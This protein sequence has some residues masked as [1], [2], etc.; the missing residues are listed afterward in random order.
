VTLAK[1]VG[2]FIMRVAMQE[3]KNGYPL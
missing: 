2:V 3:T 1:V